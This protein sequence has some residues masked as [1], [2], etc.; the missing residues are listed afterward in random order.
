MR[1]KTGKSLLVVSLL[2]LSVPAL[3]QKYLTGLDS[4][5]FIRDTVRPVVKRFEN[6]N[7][8]G[9]IQP[10]YQVTSTNGAKTYG[11]GDFST[12]SHSRFMLRR[13]RLKMD[14]L[15]VSDKRLPKALFTFQ[16]DATERSVRVRDMFIRLYET[17]NN[18]FSLTTGIFARPFGYEVNLSSSYRETPERGR[19]SQILVPSERDLGVMITYEPQEK[20]AKNKYISA[21]IGVFNG[22]G[23]SATTD[24]DN[25]KDIIGRVTLKPVKTAIGKISGGFSAL[26]GGWRQQSKY[27]YEMGS[28]NTSKDFIV[29][30]ALSNIGK[31]A[32]KHYYSGDVQLNWAHGWGATELRAEYWTGTQPGTPSAS[33]NPETLPQGPTYIRDFNGAFFYFLQDIINTKNKLLLKY[34]WYDPNT[35][36]SGK[37]IDATGKNFGAG[38][39]SYTTFG[40]G[41]LREI[42]KQVKLTL[43]YE[44]VKNE[45]T[46]LSGYTTDLSDNLFTCRI[47]YRF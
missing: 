37:E 13:A 5:L 7:F 14:Y 23:L 16:I 1:N 40:F 30:S 42:T 47:Q 29:D 31:T 17:K 25:V 10:Q 32:P 19:M 34:D 24:F 27:V 26:H 39:I 45:K 15:A 4:A 11:G 33:A 2:L 12:Y 9:Y 28:S 41:Y 22:P 21:N 18:H 35:K 38:D 46:Q 8:S 20:S 3:S 36:V 43:Y 6:L 44:I